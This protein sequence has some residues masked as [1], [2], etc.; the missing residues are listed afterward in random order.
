[1]RFTV[2]QADKGLLDRDGTLEHGF[3]WHG[4]GTV[5]KPCDIKQPFA[6]GNQRIYGCRVVSDDTFA[7]RL[8]PAAEAAHTAGDFQAGQIHIPAFGW[9]GDIQRP[10]THQQIHTAHVLSWNKENI[11]HFFMYSVCWLRI[12]SQATIKVYPLYQALSFM[13]SHFLLVYL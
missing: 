11:A 4:I 7:R 2:E 13:P 5:L 8:D 10:V 12:M 1:M 3:H 9:Q 6:A